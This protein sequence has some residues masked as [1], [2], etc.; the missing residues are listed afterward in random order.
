VRIALAER[1]MNSRERVLAALNHTQPERVPI[2]F[3]GTAVTGMHVTC[4]AALRDYYGLEKRPIRVH[5]PYQ[6]LG[7][8][9]GDLKRAMGID[10]EGVLPYDTLFGYVNRNWRP[11]KL[12]D[13]LEVLV[14]EDFRTTLDENGDTLIY[15]GGDTTVPPSGRMPKGGYFFDTI[16][17]QEPLDED[18]LNPED[19]LEEFRP[20]SGEC[21]AHWRTAAQ[22]AAGTGRAVIA[23]FGGTSFGDIALVPGPFLKHPKGIRDVAEWY[24]STR[25]RRDYVHRVFSRQCEIGLANLERIS[26]VVGD[27]VDVVM[28]C[29]TDFGTQT[30]AFC[31]EATFRELYMPYYKQVNGWIHKNTPWKTFK[32]SCGAVERFMPAFIESGFDVINPVQCSAARM[33]PERLKAKYGDKLVFW[34]GGVDTQKTL[35][36]G[37]PAQVREEVLRRCEVF[38]RN[39]GFVFNAV[40]NVQARTP[41]PNIVAMIDAVRE[42]R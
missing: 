34:G 12:E 18:H 33:E 23:N 3:G 42:F 21:L 15:P 11:W 20:V 37:T 14:P 28:V 36:F 30:S 7:W 24:M 19:N 6:M 31:S 39:G 2:D 35:P 17:R 1:G 9:D 5:E 8:I 29:G 4:V 13:R 27:A 41:V 10:V 25:A 22:E 32:H 38:S 16:I 40:H 26:P